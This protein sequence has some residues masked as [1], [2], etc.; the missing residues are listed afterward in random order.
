MAEFALE[1]VNGNPVQTWTETDSLLPDIILT[2]HIK[3]RSE[4]V[5][6]QSG[7]PVY[8]GDWY[9][10]PWFGQTLYELRSTRDEDVADARRRARTALQ[11]L[12]DSKLAQSVEVS[13]IKTGQNSIAIALRVVDRDG[14]IIEYTHFQAVG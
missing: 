6:Q 12:I 5:D 11:W 8:S 13:A 2:M 7:K 1:I 14:R 4:A 10:F 9:M 3:A